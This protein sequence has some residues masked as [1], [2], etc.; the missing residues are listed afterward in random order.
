VTQVSPS[1]DIVLYWDLLQ[2][3]IQTGYSPIDNYQIFRNDGS[4]AGLVNVDL[5]TV[6]SSPLSLSGF[7]LGKTYIF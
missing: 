4:V 5:G 1:V 6:S 2:D 7:D 3:G